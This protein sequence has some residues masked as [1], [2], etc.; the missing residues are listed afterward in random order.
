MWK[1]MENGEK[2]GKMRKNR[3]PE[4]AKARSG[5]MGP[6]PKP[7]TGSGNGEKCGKMLKNEEKKGKMLK[8]WDTWGKMR[9]HG[10]KCGKTETGSR[11]GNERQQ[12]TPSQNG[13]PETGNRKRKWGKMGKNVKN[14][15]KWVTP[16]IPLF[17]LS[18]G[19]FSSNFAGV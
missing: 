9:K 5:G 8:N 7:E 19:V 14:E 10:E 2:C 4:A 6:Q 16:Q 18:L 17:L 13:K 15:E 12:G 3:K 11:Q 1:N